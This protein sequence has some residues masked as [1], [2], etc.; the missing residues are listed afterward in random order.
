MDFP[1]TG[2]AVS[3]A[4]LPRPPPLKPDFTSP[5]WLAKRSV[6]NHYQ[7]T[8]VLG[9]LFRAIPLDDTIYH[10]PPRSAVVVLD[11][12]RTITNAL[13]KLRMDGLPGARLGAPSKPLMAEFVDLMYPFADD[14]MYYARVNTLQHRNDR[15]LTEAEV[16]VGTVAAPSKDHRLRQDKISKLQEQTGSLFSAYRK[17]IEGYAGEEDPSEQS[18]LARVALR[19]WAAWY[20]AVEE[21]QDA[22]GV[23]TFGW[24]ALGVLMEVL[25]EMNGDQ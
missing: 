9:K 4:T 2:T 22:Y 18:Q 8:R 3:H 5:E 24:L 1:K 11:P 19:A 25:A 13:Q 20:A 6:A 15:H 7:S 14:L 17:E 23:K 10:S 21:D 16:F 12:A